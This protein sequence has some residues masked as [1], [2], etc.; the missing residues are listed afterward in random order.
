MSVKGDSASTVSRN[1]KPKDKDALVG[2]IDKNIK[3][4]TIDPFTG[5]RNKLQGFILQLRLYVK[6]NGDRFRSETERVLWAV[7]LLEGK[8]MN[9]IEGFLEDY[10]ENTNEE[11]QINLRKM[12]ATTIKIFQ[13][14]DG[15]LQ[16]IRANFGIMDERREAERAIES[17]KQ[18]GS[19]VSYTRDFQRYSTKTEWGDEALKFQY[20]KGLKDFVK[21][22]LIRYSG[23]TDSFEDLIKAAC[24]ID[25]QWYERN[26][27]KKGKYDP[28]YRRMGDI[29]QGHRRYHDRGDPMELD[30]TEQWNPSGRTWTTNESSWKTANASTV[31]DQDT[32]PAIADKEQREVAATAAR[33]N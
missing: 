16:E 11:G 13:T 18:K 7:T 32:W 17:L 4:K 23:S 15:F 6:F 2:E 31:E 20:R 24:E 22:E 30:A 3:Y 1:T 21:D 27:E 33:D 8:A 10:L 5:E 9:W 14:W 26:M 19:A 25:N 28:N 29:R 12:E